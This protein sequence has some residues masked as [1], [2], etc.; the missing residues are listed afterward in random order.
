MENHAYS[1]EELV[2][3]LTS[4]YLCGVSGIENKTINNSAAYIKNWSKSLKNDVK[5]VVEASQKAQK[6]A[7][8]ILDIE[9]S[10]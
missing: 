10:S 9:K 1:K 6:A 3:E 4:A 7:D 2:A 5:M 8:Y